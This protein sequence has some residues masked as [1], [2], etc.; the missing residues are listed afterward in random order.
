MV[1]STRGPWSWNDSACCL[2]NRGPHRDTRAPK[3]R[4]PCTAACNSTWPLFAA[5]SGI[6]GTAGETLCRPTA[7]AGTVRRGRVG[8]LDVFGVSVAAA[9][10]AGSA[11]TGA[12]PAPRPGP[13]RSPQYPWA[14][15]WIVALGPPGTT[16]GTG[17]GGPG[18][19]LGV[20]VPVRRPGSWGNRCL[21]VGGRRLPPGPGRA[22]PR[23]PHPARHPKRA[24][25]RP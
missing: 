23:C 19:I 17:F 6:P 8:P 2:A 21:A 7:R 11:S 4:R 9:R 16:H 24:E 15:A 18:R 13:T 14:K 10:T 20:N 5:L 12:E 3:I 1:A 22:P 25:S